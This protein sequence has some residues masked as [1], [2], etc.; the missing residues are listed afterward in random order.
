[1]LSLPD[2]WDYSVVG[3]SEI[4]IEVKIHK[5]YV[6]SGVRIPKK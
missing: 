6:M 2:E 4:N 3:L 5:L 1:M